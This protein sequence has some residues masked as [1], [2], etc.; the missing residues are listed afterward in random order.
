MYKIIRLWFGNK[1][2]KLL[3]SNF[4][5]LTTL[6]VI[7]ILLPLITMPYLVRV[8]GAEYFGLLAFAT[9]IISYFNIITNY[10]FN[11]T[12]TRDIS[13]NKSDKLK[14]SEI[15]SSVMI[16]KFMLLIVSLLILLLLVVSFDKFYNDWEVYFFTFGVVIGQ[17]LFPVWFFQG[18]EQ[19]KYITYLN[20]LSKTIFTV[21]IFYFVKDPNDYYLVPIFTSLGYIII[22]IV[23]IIMITKKF[24]ITFKFQK[25]ETLII[26]TVSGWYMFIANISTSLYTMTTIVLL[27]FFTNN[28]IV[29]YYAIADKLINAIKQFIAPV[30]QT[31][32]PYINRKAKISKKLAL[33]II[34][35]VAIISSAISII[36][37]A[38][39]FLFSEKILFLIFGVEASNSILVFKILLII[40]FLVMLDT[41]F[42]TLLM[43]VF[44][45]NKEYTKIIIS[46]GILNLI[47]ALILI[48]L[49][50]ETG[51]AFSVLFIEL[52]ITFRI[53]L[54]TRKNGLKF[55]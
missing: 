38:I 41:V 23:S 52:Y 49:Y 15:F 36:I 10:G 17:V 26:H 6:Q 40:P 8:L 44:N 11:I 12:A 2:K 9:A 43:L 3:L 39:L 21:A 5:S 34:N 20:V 46:A 7:N 45:R 24:K 28:I 16:I 30:S 1:D 37:T 32:F 48:P 4:L 25:K 50:E 47:L 19:M 31:L 35:K 27:G 13:I 51:A 29:G 55:F 18:I 14:V 54:Y 33:I 42:G 53:I 22:G